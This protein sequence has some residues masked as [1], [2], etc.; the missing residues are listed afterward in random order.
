ML[1]GRG[2]V[3]II[4][5]GL[6]GLAHE[7]EDVCSGTPAYMA[8][9]QLAGKEVTARSDIYALGLVLHELFTGKPA[10][11]GETLEE[12][13]RVRRESTPLRDLD[14]AEEL[15]P[16]APGFYAVDGP[17]LALAPKSALRLPPGRA[18]SS[19]PSGCNVCGAS[20]FVQDGTK[21]VDYRSAFRTCATTGDSLVPVSCPSNLPGT[22]VPATGGSQRRS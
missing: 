22:S 10:L 12:I 4:D 8:P 1:D 9:E 17:S 19:A 20:D 16:Q 15:C 7:I 5:F 18:L 13:V 11:Q 3:L 6:A 14:P 21:K 2:E